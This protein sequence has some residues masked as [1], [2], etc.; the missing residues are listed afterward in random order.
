MARKRSH[1]KKPKGVVEAPAEGQESQKI[2]FEVG[3][4][5]VSRQESQ[6]D[7]ARHVLDRAFLVRG[8]GSWN[9]WQHQLMT[10][11][12]GGKDLPRTVTPSPSQTIRVILAN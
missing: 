12:V 1:K 7:T 5:K 9:G 10:V 11:L 3:G 8:N 6:V 2:S 4:K